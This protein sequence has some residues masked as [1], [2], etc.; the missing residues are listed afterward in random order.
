[1]IKE[2]DFTKAM[3]I[4]YV[5]PDRI[6]HFQRPSVKYYPYGESIFDSAQFGAKVLIALETA[7][8]ILRLNRSIEKRKITVE[9]GLPRDAAKAIEKLKE[10]FK[11]RKI[12]LDSFGSVDT[13]PSMVSSFED[14]FIP[15]KDGKAF[16][17]IANM[18]DLV[19]DTRSKTDELKF[20]RDGVIAGVGVPP[21]FIGMEEQMSAKSNLSEENVMFAR[22]IVNHQK[23]LTHQVQDLITKIYNIVD[24]EKALTILNDVEVAFP[25]PK[26]LQF[27]RQASYLSNLANLVET[28]ERVGVPKDWSKKKYLSSIDWKEVEQ[29]EIDTKIDKS[30]GTENADG[31]DGVG[32]MGGGGLMTG[33]MGGVGGF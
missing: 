19:T 24:P 2:T 21:A 22:T 28:L 4:R 5:P 17:D 29:Y 11:R 1:M 7:M 31:L 13:I 32:G 33:G 18:T 27:E 23:Y 3:N 10:E 8:T 12:S 6:Q 14:I 9:V 20:I 30:L 15:Q 26:S 25:A 16:V